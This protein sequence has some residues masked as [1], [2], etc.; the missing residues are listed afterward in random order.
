MLERKKL[1][2]IRE[3]YGDAFLLS[4]ERGMCEAP[5]TAF[6]RM[7]N[8]TRRLRRHGDR[9]V[10]NTTRQGANDVKYL[11]LIYGNDESW[12]W[13]KWSSDQLEATNREMD[14]V[15]DEFRESGELIGG[16]ALAAPT[17]TKTVWLREGVPVVTDGPYGEA[18]EVLAGYF[19][20]DCEEEDRAIE[21]ARRIQLIPSP[22]SQTGLPVEVRPVMD[23]AGLEM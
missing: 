15:I 9:V 18:K 22:E 23:D 20:I 19:L 5:V 17:R 4:R 12:D 8:R 2:E 13:E 14:K 21:L 11:V 1:D 3:R 7:S 10:A 16:H 6:P